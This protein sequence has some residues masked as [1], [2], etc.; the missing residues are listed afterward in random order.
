M[1]ELKHRLI[2]TIDGP[3]GTGKSSVA[4]DLANQLHLEFLDTGAMYR[5]ATALALDAGVPVDDEHLVSRLVRRADMRFNWAADPPT[6]YA[7]GRD[8]TERVREAD[9]NANV[10]IVAAL[11]AVRT[12]LVEA[13]RRIGEAH[14]A[15]V[16]EGRDQGTV[17]FHDAQVKFY[18]DADVT[19]RAER[20]CRQLRDMGREHEA[21]LALIS[22]Q[23][24]ERD[25]LDSTRSVGPLRC[26]SDAQ[27][28]DTSTLD[29]DQVVGTLAQRVRA[30]I[31]ARFMEHASA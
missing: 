29:Q 30:A 2:V 1:I 5:A 3:A 12:V 17:V 20:R 7:E 15:L 21:D 25:R 8:M 6:L 10:S 28:V 27:R 26:P 16:S 24:A 14:P 11:P 19:V 18:L 9:V 4:R 13:Q 23:I 31:P 22:T